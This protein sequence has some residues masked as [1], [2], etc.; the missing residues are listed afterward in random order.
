MCDIDIVHVS[1]FFVVKI[2]REG[3]PMFREIEGGKTHFVSGGGG[4]EMPCVYTTI[5]MYL[6]VNS[7]LVCDIF[8]IGTC[9]NPPTG[10]SGGGGEGSCG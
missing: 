10:S 5:L 1:R 4:G 2:F 9:K 7:L 6:K 8:R 3:K